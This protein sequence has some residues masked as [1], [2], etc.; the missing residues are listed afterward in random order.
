MRKI[1]VSRDGQTIVTNA[2]ILTFDRP[3]LPTGIKVGYL[4]VKVEPYIPNPLRCFKCQKFGHHGSKCR[5]PEQTCSQKGHD[6][7][8]CNNQ[9]RCA[10]CLG[11][12]ASFDKEC[13]LWRVEKMVIEYKVINHVSFKEARDTIAPRQPNKPTYANVL[14]TNRQ[15]TRPQPESSSNQHNSQQR[16]SNIPT[17]TSHNQS[18]QPPNSANR[19]TS[20]QDDSAPR[21]ASME[22]SSS[23]A[24]K[25]TRPTETPAATSQLPGRNPGRPPGRGTKP[26]VPAKPNAGR[27]QKG[28]NNPISQ[29]NRYG[30]LNEDTGPMD[31]YDLAPLQLV[32]QL[33]EPEAK[34][35]RV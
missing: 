5:Q 12:H 6:G 19:A 21:A 18:Q 20:K 7:R 9:I 26:V 22:S 25:G 14:T 8:D 16:A 34:S 29:Y 31:M 1:T 17:V 27:P 13:P 15:T 24:G 3:K 28:S 30:A 4:K 11:A 35:D 33:T 10:N 32:I 23:A 2:M